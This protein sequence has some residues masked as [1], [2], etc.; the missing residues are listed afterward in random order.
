M[1]QDALTDMKAFQSA[2]AGVTVPSALASADSQLGDALSAAIAADQGV[3]N[4]MD[5][6]DR[7]KLDAAYSK[8]DAAMLSFAKA[9]S[10]IAAVLS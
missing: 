9:E 10:A 3:I 8:L 2:R 1:A 6:G 5:A 7:T 4:A